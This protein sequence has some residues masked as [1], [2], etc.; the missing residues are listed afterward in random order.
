M[1]QS[2]S[3][4]A[5]DL[6]TQADASRDK[7]AESERPASG[8][9]ERAAGDEERKKQGKQERQREAGRESRGGEK[10]MRSGRDYPG[11][12]SHLVSRPPL[13]PASLTLVPS[14]SLLLL[15]LLPLLSSLMRL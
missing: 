6:Q 7:Q 5:P 1:R 2:P 9:N 13:P 15:L 12:A 10:M 11:L 4:S 8:A 14:F 3:S